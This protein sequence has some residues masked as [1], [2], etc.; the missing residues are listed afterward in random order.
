MGSDF[1][2]VTGGGLSRLDETDLDWTRVAKTGGYVRVK[3]DGE[4]IG[5]ICH[6]IVDYE[7]IVSR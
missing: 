7:F 5:A 2:T 1:L 4:R 3:R 6:G